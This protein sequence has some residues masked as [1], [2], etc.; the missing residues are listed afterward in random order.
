MLSKSSRRAFRA[1][2]GSA[3]VLAASAFSAH[4]FAFDLTSP[5]IGPGKPFTEKFLFKGLGCTGG[6]ISPALTWSAPPPGTKSFALMVHDPDAPTGGAGIWHW[7]VINIP[8]EARSI[9]Q[10]AGTGDGAKLPS[11]S[12]QVNNDYLGFT[13]TPGWGGPCPPKAAKAHDYVFTLYALGVEKIELPPIATASQA[14]FLINRAPLGK[15][16]LVVPFGRD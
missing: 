2:L 1:V 13:G 9:E 14:G 7:V 5:D 10:G 3:A 16:V 15:A 12:R 4:A 6:N 11:G 8:A